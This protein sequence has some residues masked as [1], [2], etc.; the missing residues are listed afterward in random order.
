[1]VCC[2]Q[3]RSR[4]VSLTCGYLLYAEKVKVA[5]SLDLIREKRTEASPNMG[6]VLALR[7]MERDFEF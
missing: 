6:F 2:L 3:G 4:S 7:S 5:D 1:M